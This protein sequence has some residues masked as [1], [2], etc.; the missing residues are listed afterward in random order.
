MEHLTNY[1]KMSNSRL[2]ETIKV[3]AVLIV[4]RNPKFIFFILKKEKEQEKARVSV[5]R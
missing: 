2:F 1:R 4:H 5:A 3:S